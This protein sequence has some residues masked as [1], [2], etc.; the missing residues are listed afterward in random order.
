[1]IEEE[2]AIYN[3]N[4]KKIMKD[5]KCRII[6]KYYLH[7]NL[8]QLTIPLAKTILDFSVQK[9]NMIIFNE[10]SM[11]YQELSSKGVMNLVL[12]K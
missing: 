7:I 11:T 1:M 9:Y 5:I 3:M 6:R 12:I 8:Y 2:K 10:R 4:I